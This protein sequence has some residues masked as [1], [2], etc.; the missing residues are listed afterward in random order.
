MAWLGKIIGGT[1]GFA[2]GGPLGAVAGA[3]FGHAFDATDDHGILSHDAYNRH[4]TLSDEETSQLTFFVA[5]FSMLA[6]MTQADGRISE[7]ELNTIDT[8]MKEELRLSPESHHVA[9]NIFKT[10]LNS[11]GTFDQFAH[12]FYQHFQDQ[13]QMLDL[14]LDI[15]IRVAKSDGTL[16]P[17]EEA[18]I[19]SATRIFN[20]DTEHFNQIKS[21]YISDLDKYY[22]LLQCKPKCTDDEVKHQYRKMV[23]EYHP[24]KIAA[25]GLPEEFTKFANDKFRE[26]QEAYEK[27]KH[28]RGIK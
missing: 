19:H 6:K 25:K 5:A 17:A 27:I 9:V 24:D 20:F 4:S 22:A 10:A 2:M 11:P 8:F 18:L 26:I 13:P 3:V 28:H 16:A 14:M 1:I 15:L 23:Q 21:R 7:A 12:Q